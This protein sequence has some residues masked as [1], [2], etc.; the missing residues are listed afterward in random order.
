MFQKW[1][2]PLNEQ[3]EIAFL[4]LLGLPTLILQKE[5]VTTTS[6]VSWLK[7]PAVG[8]MTAEGACLLETTLQ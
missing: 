1:A 8:T 3:K 7:Q 2:Y 4:A 5:K 6:S